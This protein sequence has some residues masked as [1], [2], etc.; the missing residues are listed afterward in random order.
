MDS[1]QNPKVIGAFLIGFA[2]VAAAY[3]TATFGE[4]RTPLIAPL[5]A[6]AEEAPARVFIPVT[7]NDVDGV[8]DWRDQFITA[9]A[10]TLEEIPAAAY[11]PPETVTGQ[12]GVS[13]VEGL[14]A[15]RAAGPIVRSEEEVV[16]SAVERL[17]KVATS[18]TIFDVKD[19][20][21]S[22]DTS[23]EALRSYGNAVASVIINES[24][25]GLEHEMLLLRDYLAAEEKDPTDLQTLAQVYKNYRDKTLNIPVPRNFVKEHL[26]LI[27]VYH[28]LYMNIDSMT[29]ASV[30]PMVPFVRLKRYED[31]V[32]G[33]S[34]ALTNMYNAFVPYA[35][36]FQMNDPAIMLVGFYQETP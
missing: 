33:L 30:D 25:P 14:I 31:D 10:V 13:L 32:K 17:E 29:K 19:I 20:V 5:A 2:L 3:V 7:D 1:Y 9:P 35:R 6:V 15:A 11:A 22:N 8:E 18:D 4:P 26:D 34:L 28:A 23:N 36:V 16:A 21:I 24:V 27:N 12:L